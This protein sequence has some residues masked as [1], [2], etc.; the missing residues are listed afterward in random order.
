[1]I[2]GAAAPLLVYLANRVWGSL[3]PSFHP[4]SVPCWRR[5]LLPQTSGRVRSVSAAN[6]SSTFSP[7][8]NAPN[9]GKTSETNEQRVGSEL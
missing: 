2:R 4:P 5:S 8:G 7:G 9:E 1:M 3:S 6:V